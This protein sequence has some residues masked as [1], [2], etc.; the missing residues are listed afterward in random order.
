MTNINLLLESLTYLSNRAQGNT[1]DAFLERNKLNLGQ[2]YSKVVELV[3][4]IREMA[5]ILD[6]RIPIS[7]GVLKRYFSNMDP[8]ID[9]SISIASTLFEFVAKIGFPDIKT[10]TIQ[11]KKTMD[12]LVWLSIFTSFAPP[13]SD[14][15]DPTCCEDFLT[16]IISLKMDPEIKCRV[17]DVYANRHR[18][19]LEIQ[20]IL[21]AV[22]AEL[23][24]LEHIYAPLL[25]RF[26]QLYM[27]E[28]FMHKLAGS[29]QMNLKDN[30]EIKLS[31]W[32]FKY[33]YIQ[34]ICSE[35]IRKDAVFVILGI[36]F[37]EIEGTLAKNIYNLSTNLPDA[38]RTLGD[39]TR[40]SIL[41][42]IKKNDTYG[43][44]LSERFNLNKNTIYHHMDKLSKLDLV[45][46][47]IDKKRVYYE[48]NRERIRDFIKALSLTL[49][50][51]DCVFKGSAIESPSSKDQT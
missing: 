18:Y 25:E 46:F 41:E 27:N 22:S 11:L 26:D 47:T 8:S 10:A 43:T 28:Q 48:L 50:D 6:K 31:P 1:V 32:I 35:Q 17:M 45:K 7:P 33:N 51:E 21:D 36:F 49:L 9:Y 42:E 16:Q 30:V 34:F 12:E 24:T 2:H 3:T 40:L 20:E 19:M 15:T 23:R 39:R 5:N 29:R 38:L 44:E 4:P 37:P 13:N 14:Y